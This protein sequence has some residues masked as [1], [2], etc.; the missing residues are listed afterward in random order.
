MAYAW[1]QLFNEQP[2]KESVLVLLSQGALET[3]QYKKMWNFNIG[4]IKSTDSDGRK[5]SF[6]K[7][8]E[9]LKRKEADR[10]VASADQ[11]GG[12]AQITSISGDI[13]TV[14][15]YP[16]NKYCRFRAFESL[17]EG[18][19]DYMSFLHKRFNSAWT[20]VL[21][22]DPKQ[23]CHFLKLKNYYT[24]NEAQYTKTVC[25]LYNQF[26]SL[27]YD[28]SSLP[29]ISDRE[30]EKILNLINLTSIEMIEEDV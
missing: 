30:K 8:N 25:A 3:G 13:A 12:P 7:C 18:A 23:F 26:N 11:D 9:L 10:L 27:N 21:A 2:K 16:N 17:E 14:W 29:V 22:G 24:A 5:Y 20:S 6:Y 1:V 19:I 28:P 15:F 4:N